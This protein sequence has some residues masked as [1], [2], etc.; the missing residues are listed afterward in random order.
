MGKIIARRVA[1]MVINNNNHHTGK[2]HGNISNKVALLRCLLGQAMEGPR[3]TTAENSSN[4]TT[5][6]AKARDIIIKV[7]HRSKLHTHMNV[8]ATVR[9]HRAMASPIL[10]HPSLHTAVTTLKMSYTQGHLGLI[11]NKRLLTGLRNKASSSSQSLATLP[12]TK[13]A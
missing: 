5:I 12:T 11:N 10:H 7:L 8:R 6:Q 3:R 2:T 9:A 1:H 13:E 4:T